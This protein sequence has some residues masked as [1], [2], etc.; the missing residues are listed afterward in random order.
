MLITVLLVTFLRLFVPLISFQIPFAGVLIALYLDIVD[1]SLLPVRNGISFME[2]AIWDKLLDTYFLGIAVLTA[3]SWRDSIASI[4]ASI[5]F[6][7]RVIGVSLFIFTQNSVMLLFFPNL[8]LPFFLFYSLFT[9]FTHTPILFTTYRRLYVV[10]ASL[11]IPTILI[12]YHLHTTHKV[13]P[14]DITQ[15]VSV[16]LVPADMVNF[17]VWALIYSSIPLTVLNVYVVQARRY[18]AKKRIHQLRFNT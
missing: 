2:Y 16:P 12:E 18:Q 11:S 3:L 6:F 1:W 10:L 4:T 7:L 9:F 5:L 14:V 8:V 17:Y 15:F 13:Y